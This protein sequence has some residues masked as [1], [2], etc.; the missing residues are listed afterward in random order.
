MINALKYAILICFHNVNV[1]VQVLILWQLERTK[2][3]EKSPTRIFNDYNPEPP[4]FCGESSKEWNESNSKLYE[5]A[6]L[7]TSDLKTDDL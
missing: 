3:L 7:S 4:L 2:L 6:L 5:C 1:P